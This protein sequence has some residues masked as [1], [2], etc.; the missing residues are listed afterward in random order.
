[1]VC[2]RTYLEST[3]IQTSSILVHTFIFYK[4]R[5]TMIYVVHQSSTLS[6]DLMYV[7]PEN[8]IV[9]VTKCGYMD[10][11]GCWRAIEQFTKMSG[12]HPGNNQALFLMVK[13]RTGMWTPLTWCKTIQY[14]FFLKLGDSTNNQP[15]NKGFNAKAKAVYWDEKNEW[16]KRFTTVTYTPAHMNIVLVTMWACLSCKS[17]SIIVNFFDKIAT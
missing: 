3:D 17:G 14:M 4:G 12:A 13:N 16:D 8:W 10:R 6:A 9:H 15:N 2:C 11:D 1:M 7:I 5:W